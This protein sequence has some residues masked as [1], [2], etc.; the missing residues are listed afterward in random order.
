MTNT[1]WA[2]EALTLPA[3]PRLRSL[4]AR[5]GG[6]ER[7]VE[8]AVEDIRTHGVEMVHLANTTDVCGGV[9]AAV[10]RWRPTLTLGAV[11]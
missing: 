10:R 2:L 9:L 1:A 8:D 7:F 3:A 6:L 4:L 5:S 11:E